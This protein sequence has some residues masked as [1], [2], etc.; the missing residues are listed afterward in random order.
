MNIWEKFD[1]E[2]KIVE[3]LERSA[4]DDGGHHFGTPFMTAYQIAIAFAERYPEA[5]ASIGK[6]IGGRNV[7]QHDSLSRY[8]ANQLSQRIKRGDIVTKSGCTIEGGF[9]SNV[10]LHDIS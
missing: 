1:V 8:L 5:F 6:P 10:C 7:G 3:I 2:K 4:G 9:L